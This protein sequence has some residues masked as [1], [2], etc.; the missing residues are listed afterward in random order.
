MEDYCEKQRDYEGRKNVSFWVGKMRKGSWNR[1]DQDELVK[2]Y[3]L[4]YSD[5]VWDSWRLSI[6]L[7][8]NENFRGETRKGDNI[9]NVNK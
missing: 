4:K 7:K 2:E 5:L 9:W 8:L 3:F 1:Y 6:S